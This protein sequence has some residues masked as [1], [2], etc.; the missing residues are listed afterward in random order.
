MSPAGELV[1]GLCMAIGLLGTFIP[2]LPGITLMWAVGLA[3][4]IL[5]GGGWIRWLLFA[6]MTAL[7]I[8]A[9]VS[10]VRIPA[11]KVASLQPARG[12]MIIAS[13]CAV[14]GFFVI[15][16]FG[17]PIGFA[18]GVFVWDLIKFREF[19]RANRV[20]RE[21]LKSFGLVALIH[22]LCGIGITT[23]WFFGLLLS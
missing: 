16:I 11:K 17:L 1:I 19:H 4:V 5:D 21:T 23:L 22:L 20:T 10:S 15:P 13:I 14:I 12:T 8:A 7:F 18:I 3:W 6:A 2:V 9:H